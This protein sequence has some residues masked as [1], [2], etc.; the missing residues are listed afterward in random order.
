MKKKKKKRIWCVRMN[1]EEG[2]EAAQLFEVRC[3][4]TDGDSIYKEL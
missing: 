3:S 2:N 1:P 4:D